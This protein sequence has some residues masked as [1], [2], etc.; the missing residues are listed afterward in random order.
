MEAMGLRKF[1][2]V[3]F[4]IPR[5]LIPGYFKEQERVKNILHVFFCESFT[6]E[7]IDPQKDLSTGFASEVRSDAEGKRIAEM[8]I[9]AGCGCEA[10]AFKRSG[11]HLLIN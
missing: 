6:V 3:F 8:K 4:H 1:I 2:F 7:V 11:A 5:A 9:T 10:G